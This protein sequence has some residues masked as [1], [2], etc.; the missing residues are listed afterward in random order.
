MSSNHKKDLFSALSIAWQLGFFIIT[1]I[2]FF[3]LLGVVADKFFHTK[4]L[5]SIG[6]IL[7][8]IIMIYDIY[9]LLARFIKTKNIN[10]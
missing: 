10:D 2:I 1:P 6:L 8:V 7:G 5:F 4:Y 9:N 3:L